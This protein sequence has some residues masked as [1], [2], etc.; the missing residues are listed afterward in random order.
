MW[1]RVAMLTFMQNTSDL[2][3]IMGFTIVGAIVAFILA[4]LLI[5]LLYRFHVVKGVKDE[6]ANLGSH[7]Y[8]ANTPV[9]GGL[10][11]IFTVAIVTYAFN[12][13]RNFT[14]VPIA[15]MLI[16]ALLG[17]VDDLMNVYGTE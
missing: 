12:W 15:V 17:A 7:S 13:S 16:A 8:K 6:L 5:R 3:Y 11:I 4:P 10:L 1:Y 2:A 9:M 14:W